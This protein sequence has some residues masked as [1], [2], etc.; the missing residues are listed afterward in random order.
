M[1]VFVLPLRLIQ[2]R[3]ERE[4]FV[5]RPELADP[6]RRAQ[7]EDARLI[8]EASCAHNWQ[9]RHPRKYLPDGR[10]RVKS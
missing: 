7:S 3:F 5:E 8:V 10:P 9:R 1:T 2:I 6:I 4:R